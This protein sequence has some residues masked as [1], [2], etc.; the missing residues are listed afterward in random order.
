MYLPAGTL[1][2]NRYEVETV[3]GHG[4]FGITYAAYDKI[5]G[6]RVAIKEYLPRHLATRS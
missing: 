3:L 5:V 1:L 2:N 4:G 6:G